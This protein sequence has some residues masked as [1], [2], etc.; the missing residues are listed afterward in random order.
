MASDK[1]KSLLPEDVDTMI[2]AFR[3]PNT[4]DRNR[5]LISRIALDGDVKDPQV[6]RLLDAIANGVKSN[7]QT[8]ETP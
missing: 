4:S 3:N 7:S 1:Q 8:P 6:Q 2:E 5:T